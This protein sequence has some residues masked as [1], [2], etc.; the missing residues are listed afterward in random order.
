MFAKIKWFLRQWFTQKHQIEQLTQHVH[1][2]NTRFKYLQQ[3]L[4]SM[5]VPR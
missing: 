3:R 2:L 1:N 5:E 4:D